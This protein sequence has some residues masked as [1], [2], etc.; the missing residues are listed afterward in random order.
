VISGL[1]AVVKRVG[2]R[3]ITSASAR[4]SFDALIVIWLCAVHTVIIGGK[5]IPGNP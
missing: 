5:S 1:W 3:A 2:A 4:D